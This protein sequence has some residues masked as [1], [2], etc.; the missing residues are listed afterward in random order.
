MKMPPIKP[1]N[2]FER[3]LEKNIHGDAQS[4]EERVRLKG[5]SSRIDTWFWLERFP[6]KFK[7]EG[8]VKFRAQFRTILLDAIE[9]GDSQV[10]RDIADALEW[11]KNDREPANIQ[12]P[13]ALAFLRLRAQFPNK[14]PNSTKLKEYT[15]Y[16][17]AD[18]RVDKMDPD[19]ELEDEERDRMIAEEIRK[20][21]TEPK[22][23]REFKRLDI[24]DKI[25]RDKG[26]RP[27]KRRNPRQKTLDTV[28]SLKS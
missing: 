9:K 21:W 5:L 3:K 10:F 23:A 26:G 28:Y 27:L 25:E 13:L 16:A 19:V 22:W 1:S 4:S 18:R 11:Q 14:K 12:E 20:Y 15:K 2:E 8:D 24:S 7:E 6:E 17:W